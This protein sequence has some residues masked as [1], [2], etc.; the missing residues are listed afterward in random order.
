M[1][2]KKDEQRPRDRQR[3][4]AKSF[5]TRIH[6]AYE[7]LQVMVRSYTQDDDFSN[8]QSVRDV[9]DVFV[10]ATGRPGALLD[11][12]GTVSHFFRF[13]EL[14]RIKIHDMSWSSLEQFWQHACT[15]SCWPAHRVRSS[16]IVATSRIYLYLQYQGIL[17]SH[18][19]DT[20]DPDICADF[21]RSLLKEGLHPDRAQQHA[22]T[23]LH[24][25]VWLRLRGIPRSCITTRV[26]DEFAMHSC[27]CGL[28]VKSAKPGVQVLGRRRVAADRFSRFLVGENPVFRDGVV[29][30]RR[31]RS[32]PTPMLLRYRAWLID[33]KGLKP[34]TVYFYLLD[35]MNWLPELGEDAASYSAKSIRDL[36]LS[37]FAKRRAN[38]Q[39]RFVRSIRSYLLFRASEG[40]CNPA[41]ANALVSRRSYRLSTVP[42]RLN[43]DD[44]RRVID[45]CDLSTIRG[46]RDRAILTLLAEL[47][48]RATEVWRLRLGS[49]NWVEAKVSIE[50]KGGRGAVV[51]LTQRAGDAVLDYLEKARPSSTLDALF[52]R[53]RCPHTQPANAAEISSI[54]SA[55]LSRCGLDGASHVFRHTL[56][57][58]LLRDGRSL[59]DVATVL[60]HKSVATTM[61]YAK[62]NEPMLK[63]LAEPWMGD[64]S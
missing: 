7:D 38:M 18:G 48:L 62:V 34:R 12:R 1:A 29:F 5:S 27:R 55:A 58:E 41:L 42:R 16:Q 31:R 43:V 36:A 24:F 4:S 40:H 30:Q 3:C 11:Y 45:S 8:V 35:V 51:P 32:E 22:R 28:H 21:L 37:Q 50:G 2:Y 59:E 9:V 60:R 63:R 26:V 10:R 44:V 6:E 47:G 57:T 14:R 20:D 19:W 25:I 54:A 56:A 64:Q 52:L 23:A 39:S 61:I 17:D 33:Q 15:R 49:F 46:I 13:L 53:M